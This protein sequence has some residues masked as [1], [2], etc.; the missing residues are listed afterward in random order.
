M[1][2]RDA[3]FPSELFGNFQRKIALEDYISRA[4]H[5][6]IGSYSGGKSGSGHSGVIK[7]DSGDQEVL[8]RSCVN[9]SSSKLG[10]RFSMGL[11]ARGRRVLGKAAS[12][13]FANILPKIVNDSCF[14]SNLNSQKVEEQVKTAEDASFI[15]DKLDEMGLVAFVA[16]GSTLPRES[17]VS[18][19]PLK[20]A[21][22]FRSPESM[23]V[24]VETPNHGPVNGMGVPKGV[25]LI[26][27]GV[28]MVSPH[29]STLLNAEFTTTCLETAGNSW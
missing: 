17:G 11:P 14:Y 19:K 3:A 7:I 15:R 16:D 26:V 24:T 1:A 12:K 2:A 10:V 5:N 23:S 4:F 9:I 13:M 25:T 28:T 8:E 20:H 27:G 6:A 21:V 22:E 18:D 29:C